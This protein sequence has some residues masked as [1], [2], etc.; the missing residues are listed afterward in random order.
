MFKELYPLAQSAPIA[1]MIAAEGDELRVT[2]HQKET[3]KGKPLQLSIL[4]TP[5]ELDENLPASI[6]DAVEAVFAKAPVAEQV[7]NQ[8]TAAAEKKGTPAPANK[9]KA[10]AS[11]PGKKTAA[12]KAVTPTSAKAASAAPSTSKRPTKDECIAELKELYAVHGN[13]LNR[14][15]YLELA[16]KT[17]RTFE[18]LFGGWHKFVKAAGLQST[19]KDETPAAPERDPDTIELPLPEPVSCPTPE[20]VGVMLSRRSLGVPRAD[21]GALSEPLNGDGTGTAQPPATDPAVPQT[22]PFPERPAEP[23]KPQ[24]A[25]APRLRPVELNDGTRICTETRDLA[26]GEEIHVRDKTYTVQT[27]G[28]DIIIVALKEPPK[29]RKIIDDEGEIRG[30]HEGEVVIGQDIVTTDGSATVARI[31]EK[32]IFVEAIRAEAA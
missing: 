11:P 13:A 28:L 23:E 4:A 15:K 16:T 18:R 12:K 22:W 17:G 14:E 2:V 6:A 19:E 5:T 20:E 1:L 3:K 21:E 8:V 9:S 31:T 24:V 30:T 7:K 32:V 10:K 27:A 26:I 25:V 29:V